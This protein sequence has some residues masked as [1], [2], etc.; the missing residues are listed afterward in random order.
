MK[1]YMRIAM[2][3]FFAI[4]SANLAAQTPQ[5]RGIE[6]VDYGLYTGTIASAQRDSLG[7]LHSTLS[8]IQH[9]KTTRDVPAKLGVRFGFRFKVLGEP[10]GARVTLR[11]ATI[12]PPGG[13][14]SPATPNVLHR[15]GGRFSANLGSEVTFTTYTFDDPWELKAGP[16][17]IEIWDGDRRLAVQEFRVFKP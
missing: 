12:Y 2:A 11:R 6:V 17:V 16:W 3:L 7:V 4:F 10:K 14:R 9:T 1:K 13:L 5:I 15:T 8:D